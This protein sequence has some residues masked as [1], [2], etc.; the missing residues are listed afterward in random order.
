MIILI[1]AGKAFDKIIHLFIKKKAL[2]KQK[3]K[4]KFLILIDYLQKNL[5]VTS[6]LM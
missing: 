1:G 4:R 5:R 6:Y 3:I 2:S